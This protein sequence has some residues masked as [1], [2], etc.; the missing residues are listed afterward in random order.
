MPSTL[1]NLVARNAPIPTWF[2]VGGSASR[3]AQPCTL[4]ELRI[5]LSIDPAMRVL[6]EGANLLVDDDG[7][8]DLVVRLHQGE[9]A[10][11]QRLDERRLRV[12]AGVNL[13]RLINDTVAWGLGGLEVLAG[14]PASMGGAIV[15][16]AGGSFGQIADVVERVYAIDPRDGGDV[17]LERADIDFSYRHSGLNHLVV[18]GADLLLSPAEPA[19]LAARKKEINDAKLK[20][21]PMSA[22]SAGCCFKNPTLEREIAGIAQAGQR[23]SAGMLIDRAGLKGLTHGTAMVSDRHANFLVVRDKKH[24]RARD[25]IELMDLV[26]LRVLDTF[27]VRLQREVVVWTKHA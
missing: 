1:E 27:G 25:V 3:F 19:T 12:G 2:E 14:V 17:V 21:Q 5:C 23:V 18:T 20:S 9:F 24:G 26:A 10:R 16:N 15:M 8:D 13:F 22:S 11:T 6:G 4:D 7:V